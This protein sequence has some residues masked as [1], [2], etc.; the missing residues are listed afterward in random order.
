MMRMT[1]WI[2]KGVGLVIASLGLWNGLLTSAN[3]QA[4]NVVVYVAGNNPV[5]LNI[6]RKVVTNPIVTLVNG[7]TSIVTGAFDQATADFVKL[8]LERRGVSA[9][10]T[11]ISQ[12]PNTLP[13]VNT[14]TVNLPSYLPSDSFNNNNLTQ[15]RYVTAVPI[16]VSGLGDLAQLQRLIPKAFISKS[17]RG[18]YIYAGGYTNRD[19]AESLKY[20][21]RSQG[22]DARVLYF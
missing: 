6:T 19:A 22:L 1:D 21:L 20:F 15:Y 8:E 14:P 11:Y 7:K 16:S 10:Q 9:Q 5:T 3:A 18:D 17:T 12:S 4:G 2:K 13:D